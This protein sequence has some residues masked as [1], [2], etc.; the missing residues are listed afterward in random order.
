M[1]VFTDRAPFWTRRTGDRVGVEGIVGEVGGRHLLEDGAG[2]GPE[3]VRLPP[4][5]DRQLALPVLR[6]LAVDLDV[7]TP[8]ENVEGL[9]LL[10]VVVSGILLAGKH[11]DDLL[12]VLPVDAADDGRAILL[13]MIHTVLV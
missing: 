2:I 6:L 3:A 13:E 12:A 7:E 10:L 11:D 9:L 8:V 1:I 5:H 4:L